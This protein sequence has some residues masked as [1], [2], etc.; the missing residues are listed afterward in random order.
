V[1]EEKQSA[2]DQLGWS[3]IGMGEAIR[4]DYDGC[5]WGGRV[6]LAVMTLY[7]TLTAARY[8]QDLII[9]KIVAYGIFDVK[10][11]M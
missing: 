5:A 6:I 8:I 7:P 2:G 1:S 3:F 4:D 10:A 9:D 11:C